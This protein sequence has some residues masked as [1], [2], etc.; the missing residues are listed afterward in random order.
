MIERQIESP[1]PMP[2]DL[3]V[4][5]ALNSR[6]AS[7]AAIPTPQ[8]ATLTST[9]CVSSWRDRITSSRG[10]SVTDCIASLPFITKLIITCCNWTRSARIMGRAGPAKSKVEPPCIADFLS[11]EALVVIRPGR[12]LKALRPQ[13]VG[14]VLPDERLRRHTPSLLERRVHPLK[15]V[16][17]SDDGYAIGRALE[18]LSGQVFRP[19][20]LRYVLAHD[21]DDRA[22]LDRHGS[23][24]FANPERRAV[25]AQLA[26]FPAHG[27]AELFEAAGDIPL[28]GVPI[29]LM[30]NIHDGTTDQFVD[31]VAELLGAKRVHG[32]DGAGCIEHEVHGRVVL[33]DGSP[34]LLALAQRFVGPLALGHVD[35]KD[36]PLVS[37]PLEKG[38]PDQ[39]WHAAAI[40]AEIFLLERLAAPGRAH[41]GQRILVGRGPLGGRQLR[42][43]YPTRD[44]VFTA[45]AQHVQKGFVGFD[46][47]APRIPNHDSDDVRVD[48]A[49]DPG[50]PFPEIVVQTGVLQ[51][52][53]RLRR[54]QVQYRD[55]GGR[56]R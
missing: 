24:G 5:K 38:A 41:L 4:K 26:E 14:Y 56:D 51:R 19:F 31:G 37:F 48:Q 11:R 27:P 15:P 20:A 1:I 29:G 53:R 16:I 25:L 3:V 45:V 50:L 43:P 49:A 40:F 52:D 6:S 13:E 46:D 21:Q 33:E 35:D 18:Y 23:G 22:V 54:P 42:P 34:S 32:H 39:N 17:W 55:S 7:S 28:G 36:N 2:P 30:K 44:K 10:R 47:P 8:S 12:L 9:R